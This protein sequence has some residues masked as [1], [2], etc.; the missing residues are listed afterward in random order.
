L[1]AHRPARTPKLIHLFL[2]GGAL[3]GT[4]VSGP[5]AVPYDSMPVWAAGADE[6]AAD[7]DNGPVE[8]YY[9]NGVIRT[10]ARYQAGKLEGKYE[11]YS[12]AGKLEEIRT[13]KADK[14]NGPAKRF[15]S[16]GRLLE[17][18]GYKDGLLSGSHIIY[19]PQGQRFVE[20][21]YERG[22]PIEDKRTIPKG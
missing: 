19:G 14:L 4:I 5:G 2:F 9:P 1:N 10:R 7:A 15:G 3:L 8:T 18:A 22:H 20:A 17:Q 11:R 16:D 13:Y 6:A 21:V 12:A